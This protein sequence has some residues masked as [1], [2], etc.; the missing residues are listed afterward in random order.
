MQFNELKTKYEKEGDPT[1]KK[2]IEKNKAAAYSY[3]LKGVDAYNEWA[4]AGLQAKI[5]VSDIRKL[6]EFHKN[7]ISKIIKEVREQKESKWY[8]FK[9]KRVWGGATKKD[10]VKKIDEF[11]LKHGGP[12]LEDISIDDIFYPV[13]GLFLG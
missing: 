5:Q 11:M 3:M 2:Q 1:N 6:A 8:E 12:D 9:L 4:G 13:I 7:A 10:A